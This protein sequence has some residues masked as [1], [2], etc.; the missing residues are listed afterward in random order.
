M[1]YNYG[2]MNAI[3]NNRV[4]IADAVGATVISL[5]EAPAGYAQFH[6]GVAQKFVIDPHGLVSR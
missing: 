4:K 6:S 3:L 5:E 2:L 1:K